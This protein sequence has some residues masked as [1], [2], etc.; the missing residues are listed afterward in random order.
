MAREIDDQ[1]LNFS[2]DYLIRHE[3]YQMNKDLREKK[4]ILSSGSYPVIMGLYTLSI[5]ETEKVLTKSRPYQIG[6]LGLIRRI[7]HIF[8]RG[9]QLFDLLPE[10]VSEKW[11][12]M[13]KDV[14]L[15]PA[16][17]SQAHYHWKQRTHDLF[18]SENP[19]QLI[20]EAY[21]ELNT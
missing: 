6:R 10:P 17:R 19:G 7:F 3:I 11:E 15:P 1:E 2:R 4:A 13:M 21:E 16:I 8:Q 5:R 20:H 12:R 14:D 18:R 9:I